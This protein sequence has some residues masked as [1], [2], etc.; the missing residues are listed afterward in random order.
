[1]EQIKA[2]EEATDILYQAQTLQFHEFEEA[3]GHN[4]HS[5][6]ERMVDGARFVFDLDKEYKLIVDFA[7]YSFEN[8]SIIHKSFDDETLIYL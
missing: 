7:D 5:H 3:H 6:G 1:M 8:F 2:L 4:L